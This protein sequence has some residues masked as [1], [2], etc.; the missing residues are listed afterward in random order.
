MN[1]SPCQP[2]DTVLDLEDLKAR[3]LGNMDLVER[4]LTK[5]AGQLDQ[6]LDELEQAVGAG[7]ATRA[8]HFA[9]R[10]KGIAASVA[11][12]SLFDDASVAEERALANGLAEMPEELVRLRSDRSRLAETLA[13]SERRVQ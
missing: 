12:R 7:D 13:K 6:D 9:H 1:N 2:Q 4:V 5:F 3:C 8:A 11:A 10:I